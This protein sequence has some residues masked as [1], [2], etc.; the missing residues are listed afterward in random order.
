MCK[1]M[2]LSIPGG[3]ALE[4]KMT[5]KCPFFK[6]FPQPAQEKKFFQGSGTFG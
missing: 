6:E 2:D 3:R 4:C 1:F 5:A